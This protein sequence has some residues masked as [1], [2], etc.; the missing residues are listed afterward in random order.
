MIHISLNPGTKI[1]NNVHKARFCRDDNSYFY[2]FK[3]NGIFAEKIVTMFEYWKSVVTGIVTAILA[4]LKPIEGEMW[5][6]FL[7][8]LLNFAFGYLSGMVANGEEF[9]FRKA[10]KCICEAT[11]FSV[12]CVAIYALGKL[13]GQEAGSLQCVSFITYTIIY[14]YGLNI[15]KNLKK[16]FQSETAPWMVVAF[17]YYVL[18]FKFIERIPFLSDYMNIKTASAHETDDRQQ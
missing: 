15:L 4:Y 18:R 10:F 3:V 2:R 1:A 6:L 11:V 16:V 12:L 8:F 5:S 13:K 7:I 9:E 14:F 17:L